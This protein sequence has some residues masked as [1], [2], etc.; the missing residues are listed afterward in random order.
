MA[1]VAEEIAAAVESIL[2]DQEGRTVT[3]VRCGTPCEW[4]RFEYIETAVNQVLANPLTKIPMQPDL[5]QE[6][7]ER[8]IE[9]AR[10]ECWG[11]A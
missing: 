9:K 6:A 7:Y 4:R 11:S 3:D 8:L 1:R 2:E 10:S 5:L